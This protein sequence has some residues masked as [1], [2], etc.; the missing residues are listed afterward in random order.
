MSTAIARPNPSCLMTTSSRVTNTLKTTTMIAAALVTVPDVI[1]MPRA[2]AS[3]VDRPWSRAS[4]IRVRM[5][6]W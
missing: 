3:F 5:K 2:T 6:T 4:L 1:A